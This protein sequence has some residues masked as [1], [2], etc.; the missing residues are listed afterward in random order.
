MTVFF[1]TIIQKLR[2]F[3]STP[4]RGIKKGTQINITLKSSL[5]CTVFVVVVAISTLYFYIKSNKDMW[6]FLIGYSVFFLY[7]EGYIQW[8]HAG[9]RLTVWANYSLLVVILG[10]PSVLFEI[11]RTI[12]LLAKVIFKYSICIAKRTHYIFK[13]SFKIVCFFFLV[14]LSK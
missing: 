5:S 13:G 2:I 4:P 1:N 7:Y 9:I 14:N 8:S 3:L 6:T 12:W 10:V 11:T